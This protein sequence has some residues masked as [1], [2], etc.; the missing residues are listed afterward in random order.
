MQNERRCAAA[1]A[2]TAVT[3]RCTL[4]S[5]DWQAIQ[6][7]PFPCNFYAL[8]KASNLVEQG[9]WVAASF[10]IAKAAHCIWR[11]IEMAE[12][13]CEESVIHFS[14]INRI[15]YDTATSFSSM[16]LTNCFNLTV[17]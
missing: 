5:D 3:Q 15:C 1:A 9:M 13:L 17:K 8:R 12:T 11:K 7:V 10:N 6:S 16:S 2:A 4:S 14:L